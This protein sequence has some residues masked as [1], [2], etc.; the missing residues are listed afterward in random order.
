MRKL[1]FA[2]LFLA[3]GLSHELRHPLT[4]QCLVTRQ[5]AGPGPKGPRGKRPAR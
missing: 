1:W 5:A 4:C 2:L 3:G